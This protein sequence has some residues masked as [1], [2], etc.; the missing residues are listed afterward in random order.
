MEP[1][2]TEVVT[3]KAYVKANKKPLITGFALGIAFVLALI[4]IAHLL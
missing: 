4:C 2:T 1:L 3:L